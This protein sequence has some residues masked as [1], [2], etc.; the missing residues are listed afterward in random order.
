MVIASSTG[1]PG[2]LAKI[3]RGLPVDF[4]A[5]IL[6]VQHIMAGFAAGLATWL[7]QLAPLEVRLAQH[8]DEPKVGQVLIAPDNHHM[9]INNQGL[10]SLNQEPPQNGLRP[11]AN[12]LFNSAAQVYGATTIGV[13]LTGMGNDGAEGLLALR[14]TGAH[15]IAQ[16]ETSCVVF[17][18]PAVAIELGAAE[19]ILPADKIATAL[20]ALV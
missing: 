15:T 6:I 14:E 19:Q 12:Y 11:S 10:I 9:L 4:P 17:G 2:I 7:N 13:I 8:A 3:L 18:M 5:P 20:M 16:D 1:G